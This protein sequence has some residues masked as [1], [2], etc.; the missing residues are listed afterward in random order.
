MKRSKR[1]ELTL[2][3]RRTM[4]M[5]SALLAVACGFIVWIHLSWHELVPPSE[6]NVRIDPDGRIRTGEIGGEARIVRAEGSSGEPIRLYVDH[7]DTVNPRVTLTTCR[8]CNAAKTSQVRRGRLVCGHC[9]QLMPLLPLVPRFR[10]KRTARRFRFFI[11][12]KAASWWCGRLTP[13]PARGSSW[14]PSPR[15]LGD[16][17]RPHHAQVLMVENMA[18]EHS[19]A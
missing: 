12:W 8:R 14:E 4:A 3:E 17:N 5:V 15:P 6:V 1:K 18:M 7:S 13:P 16:I 11:P 10:R 2:E 9:G 19:Q